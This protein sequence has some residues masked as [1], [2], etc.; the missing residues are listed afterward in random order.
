MNTIL[1]VL[2]VEDEQMLAEIISD[3]LSNYN[4][5]ITLA[6]DGR[7]ALEI[8]NKSIFDVIVSDIMMPNM[9]GFTL[10]K[11]LRSEGVNTP[12]LFLTARS[13]TDDIV[14][15]FEIG[16]NDYLKK[17][18]AMDELIVRIR[19]LAGRAYTVGTLQKESYTLGKYTFVPKNNTLTDGS[20]T[21]KLAARESA[22]LEYLC[23]RLGQIV[24]ASAI[25]KSLWGNDNFF[26]LR[27]LNVYIT[28]LRNHFKED[29]S[30]EIISI[31]GVGY[32]MEITQ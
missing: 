5:E 11:K 10:V 3:T 27:S 25:L 15:G 7:Q 12:V 19:A 18:F 6:H 29:P 20:G 22:V 13:A 31:R 32:R 14:K 9:D 17:P 1:K 4:F 2:L 8:A 26:T 23:S 24:E 21:I 30:I 28:K 16:G